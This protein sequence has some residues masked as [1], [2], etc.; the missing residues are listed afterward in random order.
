M[1][2]ASDT[3]PRRV[4][5]T[6]VGLV[7]PL[8]NSPEQLWAALAEGRSG[9][10]R[11]EPLARADLPM[12]IAGLA[13]GFTGAIDDFGD[14]P[15][16]RKKAIRKGLKL[17]CRETQMAVAAAQLALADAG[18]GEAPCDPETSGVVLGSDYMLTMPADYQDAMIGCSDGQRFDYTK[19]GGQGLGDMQPL[20]MLRYLPNMPASHIAIYNDLRG[21]NNSLT[22][23]EA[24]GLMAIGEA[25]RIVA[26][27]HAERMIAGATGTR[28]L[29]LQAIHA[30]QTE[31]M[32][33]TAGDP[34]AASRPF[35]KRRT[36]MVAGEGA[37]MV[38]LES[39]ESAQ[40]RGAKVYGEVLG[41]GS[42][43]VADTNLK[44]KNDKAI[45]NALSS[46]LRDAGKTPAELGHLNAHGLASPQADID[47]AKAFRT[48]LGDAA[49]TTPLIAPKA[50]F[51]NLG[52]GSG[53]VELIASLLALEHN[54][55][56]RVL[57][58]A[59]P[60][61][62]CPVAPVTEDGVAPGDLFASV[63]TT[64][65]GQAAAVCVA[66]TA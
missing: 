57:N 53:V 37:G 3:S 7:S 42:S 38:M 10:D 43:Q 34:A 36:G 9:V 48:A 46:A 30:M 55:L 17:M 12:G 32:A 28:V 66:R 60:D 4:V 56:P 49:A 6:G 45:A 27:G 23:R 54:A 63:N 21:P 50:G 19:W 51:G 16:D 61:P 5:I 15:K 20:W 29:P 44:G 18:H 2:T 11:Y 1:T 26:R 33:D 35:D 13:T 40:A 65:Q 58:Y 25:L 39:L 59:E 41:F 47:E 52:A 64:P 24:S 8:G 22:M 62:Q 31:Q 14:L